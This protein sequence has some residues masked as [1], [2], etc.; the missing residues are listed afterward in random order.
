MTMLQRALSLCS[1]GS[2][3]SP[4]TKIA[5]DDL[6]EQIHRAILCPRDADKLTP[7]VAASDVSKAFRCRRKQKAMID[8]VTAIR[9]LMI[10]TKHRR[11]NN[12]PPDAIFQHCQW[13][14]KCMTML[15]RA[16]SMCSCGNTRCPAMKNARGDIINKIHQAILWSPDA[17]KLPPAI[18]ANGV[19]R[20]FRSR[21]KQKAVTDILANIRTLMRKIMY[22]RKK[23]RHSSVKRLD[24]QHDAGD[25]DSTVD[26]FY[27]SAHFRVDALA[28]L[29]KR[30]RASEAEENELEELIRSR[31]IVP[32]EVVQ[33]RITGFQTKT[34]PQ[35]EE[36]TLRVCAAC[37]RRDPHMNYTTHNL[38]LEPPP[39]LWYTSRQTEELD[40]LGSV[41]LHTLDETPVEFPLKFLRNY[42]EFKGKYL[43]CIPEAVDAEKNFDLCMKCGSRDKDKKPKTAPPCDSVAAGMDYGRLSHLSKMGVP[44]KTSSLENLV[45]ASARCYQVTCKVVAHNTTRGV[46]LEGHGII[47]PQKVVALAE[48]DSSF[49]ARL[50]A[51]Y[52]KVRVLFVGPRD[53]VTNME[54][55]ALRLRSLQLRYVVLHNFMTLQHALD[56]A[57]HEAPPSLAEIKETVDTSPVAQGVTML[58]C[59]PTQVDDDL[60]KQ[61]S[62]IAA[63]R[64]TG[65]SSEQR[66]Q[67]R[68]NH[69]GVKKESGADENTD[70][71]PPKDPEPTYLDDNMLGVSDK[72][73]PT[74]DT[75]IGALGRAVQP[76][77]DEDEGEDE[78]E[79][80]NDRENKNATAGSD[81]LLIGRAKSPLNDYSQADR[82][83]YSAFWPLF[84]LQQGLLARKT[85]SADKWRHMATYFDCRCV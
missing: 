20:A 73:E 19:S 14:P 47:F 71:P 25:P 6:I 68:G 22:K 84:P 34:S 33:E 32:P 38:H 53:K 56:P 60:R 31:G 70:K 63:V 29:V 54:V 35:R 40:Q 61:Q 41:T 28:E 82:A 59:E 48:S 50:K 80:S 74:M 11:R 13:T 76:D 85:I 27:S 21:R 64:Q 58:R 66:Q 10:K 9:T 79:S 3:I 7:A 65:Q 81:K 5:R 30:G 36:H 23:K 4:T 1:Y 44:T 17:D 8:V 16:L 51:A 67:S 2:T 37:G 39:W 72:V 83:L 62:D 15:Q 69:K 75:L 46:R 12:E 18:T 42:V 26:A 57:M 78:D 24:P 55:L 43:H 45:L 52:G 49:E 77:E